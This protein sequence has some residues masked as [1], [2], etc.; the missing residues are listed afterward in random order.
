LAFPLAISGSTYGYKK[1]DGTFVGFRKP[2]GTATSAQVLSGYTFSNAN[3]DGLVGSYVAPKAVTFMYCLQC[4][5]NSSYSGGYKYAKLS[6]YPVVG[7]GQLTTN[8]TGTFNYNSINFNYSFNGT[9]GAIQVTI[10]SSYNLI[11]LSPSSRCYEN[12]K[13]WSGY[14]YYGT[15]YTNGIVFVLGYH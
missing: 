1:T 8:D 3:G 7:G 11:V 12:V 4:Q 9:V 13:S 14:P 6:T 5:D 10:S 15:P 2:T